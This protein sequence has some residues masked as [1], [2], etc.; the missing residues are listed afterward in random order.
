MRRHELSDAEWE[1]VRPLLPE[2]LRGRKRLDDRRVLNGIVWKFRTGTAWRDVPER[3]GPWATLHTRFRRWA[4]DGTF[5]RMLRAAQARADAAGDIEWLVSVD[6]TIVRAHQHA[7]GARKGGL[8]DPALGRSRGGLTSKIHLACDGRGRPLGF[9]V[10]GG[11][12]NDCT[13]FT[14]VME[15][16]RVP[17][18]GPG[19]PRIRPDHVLGDKGYSSRAIRTWLRRHGIPHTIPERAD[20]VRNRARRGSHGGRPPAFDREAYKHRNVVERCFN[21][22]KQWRGIATRYDKTAQAYQAAVTLA[23]LLMWA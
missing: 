13:R 10:T 17:R 22:L 4:A 21:R 18:L 16:I 12:T 15:A 3:Y 2:S 1:F 9:V 19:R 11:S 7:A 6:S 8:R 14:A 20:Q 23:S 5:D